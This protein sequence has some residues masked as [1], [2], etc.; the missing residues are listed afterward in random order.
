MLMHDEELWESTDE[1]EEEE[2]HENESDHI[3][4]DHDHMERTKLVSTLISFMCIFLLAWQAIFRVP[5]VAIGL[6][7]KFMKI[8]LRKINEISGSSIIKEVSELLPDTLI[9]AQKLLSV[10]RDNFKKIIVCQMC[11]STYDYADCVIQKEN[12]KCSF[13][14]FPLHPRH[15]LRSKC[16]TSLLKVIK[17]ATGKRK[18][19]PYKVFCYKSI[20]DAIKELV[21][22]PGIIDIFNHWKSHSIPCNILTDVYDGAVWKSF[23]TSDDGKELLSSRY[24]L[25]LIVNVDWFQPYKHVPY[26]VG[27]IY[28]CVLNFPRHMRY[29]QEN[30][31]IVGIIPGPHEPKLHMNSLL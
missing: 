5:N 8:L 15:T 31:I 9:K 2:S 11:H 18:F 29:K 19:V 21:Q 7:F 4:Q 3:Q 30:I 26:S 24:G 28:I 16:G 17:T 25:A 13:I 27:V 14:H 6:L 23:K 20:I 1:E 22:K 12:A 10:N